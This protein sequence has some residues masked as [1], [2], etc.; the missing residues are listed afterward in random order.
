MRHFYSL[1]LYILMPLALS[2]LFIR[3]LA[4]REWWSRW[5]ERF[6]HVNIQGYESGIVVH[7][8]S[9]GE[10]NAALPLI[11]AIERNWPEI[12]VTVTCFTPTGSARIRQA[13]GSRVCHVYS[14]FDLPGATR[15]FFRSLQPRLLI[16]METE[17]W[18]NLFAQARG[19]G[20]PVIIA[21][22]RMTERSFRRY[23]K[24]RKLVTEAIGKVNVIAAQSEADQERFLAL[25]AASRSVFVP[26]N[27]KFDLNLPDNVPRAGADLRSTWGRERPVIVGGSTHEAD[28]QALISAYLR[29][30]ADFPNALLVLAPRHP[31]RFTQAAG[32]AEAQGLKVVSYTQTPD[33][34][35]NVQCLIV[36][37]LG[38]LLQ[39]Y[40]A[41]DVVFIGGTISDVGGHN[42]LEAAALGRPIVLGPNTQ[43]IRALETML[44]E[45]GAA[46]VLANGQALA[47]TL[48]QLL[49]D[50]ARRTRMG[51][52]GKALVASRRGALSKTL[53]QVEK[54][55]LQ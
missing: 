43:N 46:I 48:R 17:I 6:G 7:A 16:V 33:D 12:P 47:E 23:S 39:V 54:L 10:V 19:L 13:L 53:K 45:A 35:G 30:T 3:G 15:R 8:V 20:C 9:V 40:S 22:A 27:I 36:D 44:V 24:F 26:G 51:E 4:D 38:K 28:E 49:S 34:F 1:L 11:R 25:G 18:P 29:L 14:P 32:N 55:L 41:A 21:N 37:T 5:G 2:Y 52:A 50:Q 42:P 31:E